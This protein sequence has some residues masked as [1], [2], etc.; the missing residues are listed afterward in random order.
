M[1]RKAILG[2][3]MAVAV[4]S[5]AAED[6]KPQADIVRCDKLAAYYDRYALM[7]E[8]PGLMNRQIGSTLCRQGKFVEGIAELEKA[9]HMLG[10]TPP[11]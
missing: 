5:V 9:I 11:G 4:S 8:K 10:F 3:A 6:A 1:L 7:I 2:L